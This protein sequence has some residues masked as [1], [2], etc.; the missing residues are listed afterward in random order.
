MAGN[1]RPAGFECDYDDDDMGGFAFDDDSDEDY[2]DAPK[3][4]TNGVPSVA[5]TTVAVP[6]RPSPFSHE[7]KHRPVVH[8]PTR[9]GQQG[10]AGPVTNGTAAQKEGGNMAD[11]HVTMRTNGMADRFHHN[12]GDRRHRSSHNI[13]SP[14]HIHGPVIPVDD[15]RVAVIKNNVEGV[16]CFLKQGL[17]VD[18]VF[19]A[20]WT[21]LMYAASC[22]HEETLTL[23]LENGAD[24]NFH[25]HHYT[26]LMAACASSRDRED[27]ILSCMTVTTVV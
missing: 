10:P 25:K 12:K 21:S 13:V 27:H 8:L 4:K 19:K 11:G 7:Q 20:R 1:F 15:F 2:G 6:S 26:V 3:A 5:V 16:K 14:N 9:P 24:P 17:S 18:T 22:A 23:L